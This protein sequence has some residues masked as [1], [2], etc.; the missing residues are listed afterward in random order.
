[1]KLLHLVGFIIKKFVMMHG[2]TNVKFGTRLAWIV[3]CD[4]LLLL[5]AVK[6]SGITLVFCSSTCIAVKHICMDF[7][8]LHTDSDGLHVALF[9]YV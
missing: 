7:I 4:I 6:A 2:H 1:V 8:L 9:A 3:T 5:V